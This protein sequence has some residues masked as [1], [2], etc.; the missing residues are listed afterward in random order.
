MVNVIILETHVTCPH[1]PRTLYE[2]S[3]I[4]L[5][6]D[7]ILGVSPSTKSEYPG[8]CI[9]L[10][11]CAVLLIAESEEEVQE[12]I[13][14]PHSMKFDNLLDFISIEHWENYECD[15]IWVA[16]NKVDAEPDHCDCQYEDIYKATTSFDL[17][18]RL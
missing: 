16:R 7:H 18:N 6:I 8:S 5:N 13:Q 3:E 14:Y 4:A 2:T 17:W 12:K 9:L 10:D 11:H 1:P 15:R